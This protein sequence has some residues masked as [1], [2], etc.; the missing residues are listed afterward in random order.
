M[1]LGTSVSK[2]IFYFITKTK[3]AQ[4]TSEP[5]LWKV[6]Q[7]IISPHYFSCPVLGYEYPVLGFSIVAYH[8]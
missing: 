8:L 1:N 3:K 5:F 6:N 7:N 4:N 2:S